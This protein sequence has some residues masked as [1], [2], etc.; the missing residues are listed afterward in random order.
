MMT[1]EGHLL[2]LTVAG[3]RQLVTVE[4]R[5]LFMT[6][7]AHRLFMIV[8]VRHQAAT[9]VTIVKVNVEREIVGMV[10]VTALDVVIMMTTG[11]HK[12]A[13]NIGDHQGMSGDVEGRKRDIEEEGGR[14]QQKKGGGML[15]HVLVI[16]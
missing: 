8:E 4:A 13:V 1:V 9:V 3:H 15:S 7:V 10:M 14:S 6:V 2:I 5:P 11:H 16:K 12:A